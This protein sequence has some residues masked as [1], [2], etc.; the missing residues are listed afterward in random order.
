MNCPRRTARH[1][2]APIFRGPVMEAVTTWPLTVYAEGPSPARSFSSRFSG[3]GNGF[4][5]RVAKSTGRPSR[6]L[7]EGGV[8]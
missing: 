2:E 7:P 3:R 6:D 8:S 1:V 5:G 4:P